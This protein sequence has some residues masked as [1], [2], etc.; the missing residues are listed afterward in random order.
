VLIAQ[1]SDMHVSAEGRFVYGR[2]DTAAFLARTVDHI[3]HLDTRPDLV[4]ATGDLVDK[5]VDEEYRRLRRL[6]A[7][8]DMPVYLLPRNHDDRDALRREFGRDG[9][10]PAS[11]FLQYVVDAGDLRLI[12]LDTLRPRETGGVLDD[13]RLAWLDARLGEAPDRPTV[14]FLHHPPFRTG[15][16]YMDDRGLDRADALAAVVRGHSQVEG[17]MAGHLHRAIQRRWANTI[18]MTAPSTAHQ[19]VL[20][21][22]DDTPLLFSMEPPG[23]LLHLWQPATG[24][25]SHVVNV[26]A[27][28]AY[29]VRSSGAMA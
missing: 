18:A 22:R 21:V 15:V 10:L 29:S 6:L 5:A 8:L 13:E 20:D 17:V 7:P 19:I 3:L 2:V 4:V 27:F 28:P 12:V 16:V 1:I 11:G 14:I 24:L 9:Y 26:G 23:Y 25:V